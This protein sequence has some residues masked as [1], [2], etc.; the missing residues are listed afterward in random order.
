MPTYIEMCAFATT[1]L[2]VFTEQKE[3]EERRLSMKQVN[4]MA[5][6]VATM[7]NAW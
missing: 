3:E 2:S 1:L 6:L 4:W 5:A 7:G